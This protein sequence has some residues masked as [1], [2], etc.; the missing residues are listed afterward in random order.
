MLGGLAFSYERGTLVNRQPEF[1]T[2]SGRVGGA[3]QLEVYGLPPKLNPG[4]SR[5][6]PNKS[7]NRRCGCNTGSHGT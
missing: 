5:L 1:A 2:K 6:I 7:L 3:V 4:A